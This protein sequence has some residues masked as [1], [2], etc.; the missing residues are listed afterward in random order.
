M[1][2]VK[3]IRISQLEG[4]DVIRILQPDIKEIQ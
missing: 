2:F 3:G 4:K 1:E